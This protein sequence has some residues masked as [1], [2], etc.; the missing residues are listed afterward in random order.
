M[1]EAMRF[2]VDCSVLYIIFMYMLLVAYGIVWTVFSERTMSSS[3][4]DY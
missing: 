2:V 3:L 1:T 4:P